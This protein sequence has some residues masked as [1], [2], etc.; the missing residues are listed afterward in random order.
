MNN[1]IMEQNNKIQSVDYITI[2]DGTEEKAPIPSIKCVSCNQ[3]HNVDLIYYC[4]YHNECFNF[5]HNLCI[6]CGFCLILK[7]EDN[8]NKICL[9]CSDDVIE[10]DNNNTYNLKVIINKCQI[11]NTE[12]NIAK[13][14]YCPIEKK[15]FEE[16]DVH[17]KDCNKCHNIHINEYCKDCN[18]CYDYEHI[19]CLICESC[20]E[21]ENNDNDIC[22]SCLTKTIIDGTFYTCTNCYILHLTKD[23]F[24]YC[25]DCNICYKHPKK[26][27]INHDKIQFLCSSC[28]QIHNTFAK[29]CL[30]CKKCYKDL[31]DCPHYC[32]YKEMI[33]NININI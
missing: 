2:D 13:K 30:E 4:S 10:I 1:I 22:N 15:C 16:T 3:K 33:D 12:H 20:I 27:T 19:T 9:N 26:C 28:K 24:N 31:N 6:K 21:N 11:C 7:N 14:Q 17:C 5:K 8:N 25:K 18:K 29:Y 32:K 23:K